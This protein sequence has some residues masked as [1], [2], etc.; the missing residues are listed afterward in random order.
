VK[1]KRNIKTMQRYE[2]EEPYESM[3]EVKVE[4]NGEAV[5]NF[6]LSLRQG[7]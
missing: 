2:F 5:V 1:L 7:T 6:D 4:A 3:Q